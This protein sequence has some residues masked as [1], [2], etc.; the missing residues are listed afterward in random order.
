MTIDVFIPYH[1]FTKIT[2]D[3]SVVTFIFLIIL[4]LNSYN[5]ATSLFEQPADS[6]ELDIEFSLE[7]LETM[8]VIGKGSGGVVQL[9]RHKWL[10]KLFALKVGLI[11]K[12]F[13]YKCCF[14]F[15]IRSAKFLWLFYI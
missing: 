15:N 13:L 4:Y 7:D 2:V 6:K 8:K 5:F 3:V 9:V 10:G 11:E 14:S 1:I 12:Q